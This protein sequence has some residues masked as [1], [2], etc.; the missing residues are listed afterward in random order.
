MWFEKIPDALRDRTRR[1]SVVEQRLEHGN[2]QETVFCCDA[3]FCRMGIV[4]VVE[5]KNLFDSFYNRQLLQSTGAG[6]LGDSWMV[7]EVQ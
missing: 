4:I 3:K 6:H 7:V 1:Y 5:V 2:C